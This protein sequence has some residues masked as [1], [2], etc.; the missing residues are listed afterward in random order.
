MSTPIYVASNSANA[1]IE[2]E[3]KKNRYRV[4]IKNIKLT[5]KK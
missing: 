2:I 4:T 3:F 5:Q 1:F